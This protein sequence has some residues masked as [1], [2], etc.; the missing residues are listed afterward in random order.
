MTFT[1]AVLL[2]MNGYALVGGLANLPAWSR[3]LFERIVDM[4]RPPAW[5]TDRY[6]MVRLGLTLLSVSLIGFYSMRLVD[7]ALGT[8]PSYVNPLGDPLR[9]FFVGLQAVAEG[10]FVWVA[11]TNGRRRTWWWYLAGLASWTVAF[12]ALLF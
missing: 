4:E 3:L 5:W 7:F 1:A 2:L 8:L 9:P 10:M 6:L 12:T 11:R